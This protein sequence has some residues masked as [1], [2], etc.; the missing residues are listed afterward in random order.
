MK[1]FVIL[2]SVGIV[3][4][5]ALFAQ[6]KQ[7]S[8]VGTSGDSTYSVQVTG[9]DG[10]T[11]NC[12]PKLRIEDGVKYRTCVLD[13]AVIAGNGALTGGTLSGGA[14]AGGVVFALLV[15]AA[16]GGDGAVGTTTTTTP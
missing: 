3:S 16:A 10:Q 8:V 4:A 5:N 6:T 13:G 9:S 14:V 2:A 7:T 1:T 12:L 15:A 11:Y